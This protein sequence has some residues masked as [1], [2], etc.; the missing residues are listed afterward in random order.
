MVVFYED[1]VEPVVFHF[2]EDGVEPVVFHFY[3]DGIEPVVFH[4]YGDGVEPVF[5]HFKICLSLSVH[6]NAYSLS[7]TISKAF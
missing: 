7:W 5:F 1:G 4:F 2:Y 3:E 6:E